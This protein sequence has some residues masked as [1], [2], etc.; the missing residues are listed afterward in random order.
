MV[1]IAINKTV[2]AVK[3][4]KKRTEKCPVVEKVLVPQNE[5]LRSL[6]LS[7]TLFATKS[8]SP[9]LSGLLPTSVDWG[10]IIIST[11]STCEDKRKL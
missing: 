10:V 7:L 3:K 6:V 11:P 2:S 8:K 5:D 1:S 9:H 4:S